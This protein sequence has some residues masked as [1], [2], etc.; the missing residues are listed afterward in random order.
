[1]NLLTGMEILDVVDE[2]VFKVNSSLEIMEVNK[3]AENIGYD[4]D[5]LKGKVVEVLISPQHR[6]VFRASVDTAFKLWNATSTRISLL[7]ARGEHIPVEMRVVPVESKGN[8]E[9]YIIFKPEYVWNFTVFNDIP[10]PIAVI[11]RDRV[12]YMNQRAL[13]EEVDFRGL[14]DGET[15]ELK[16]GTYKVRIVDTFHNLAKVK[17]VILTEVP[18]VDPK[19][20]RFAIAGIISSLISHDIKNSL[21]S[22]SLLVETVKDE[23]VKDKLKKSVGRI[24]RLHSRVLSV[25]KPALKVSEFSLEEMVKEICEDLSYKINSRNLDIKLEIPENFELKTDRDILYEILHN[26]ISNAI[27]ASPI[28][29]K[30]IISCGTS[31]K[32]GEIYKYVS[33][34]DFGKG[35]DKEDLNRIFEPFFTTKEG[36]TGLGLFIVKKFVKLL[37]GKIEVKSE[38]GKGSEFIVYLKA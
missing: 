5:M 38:V 22:L 21:M 16:S 23:G 28:K 27:D 2:I 1:M 18:Q 4:V 37:G 34:R 14:H 19:L 30:I 33:I 13:N 12:L 15:V 11:S 3:R 8:A 25:I 7:N 20:E 10:Y 31:H 26:L 35:I 32:D 17:I 9:Y 36:G 24:K 6:R 29:G